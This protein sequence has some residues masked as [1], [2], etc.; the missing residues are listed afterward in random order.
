MGR[1]VDDNTITDESLTVR[2]NRTG[3]TYTV[4]YV[5]LIPVRLEVRLRHGCR[6]TNNTVSATAFKAIAAPLKPGERA[7]NETPKGLRVSDKGFLNTAVIQSRITYIDGDAGILRYRGYP[8]EQLA[9]H[10]THLET[11]YLLIYGT[12][13]SERQLR[14]FESEVMSHTFVHAD[15]ENF[16]RSFRC[17]LFLP[18]RDSSACGAVWLVWCP[19]ADCEG[20]ACLLASYDAHPMAIL[21]SAFSYLGSY[22]GEANPSLQGTCPLYALSR[23]SSR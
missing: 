3:R 5:A 4:P 12:L 13:P 7:E 1:P 22:Y 14:L 8:I 17:V 19:G 10:S 9:Q 2:D 15:A 6:I 23:D 21:T 11:A 20:A 16:F 18:V